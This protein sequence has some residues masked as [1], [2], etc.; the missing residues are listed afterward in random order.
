M[1]YLGAASDFDEGLAKKLKLSRTDMRCLELIG[2]LGP[3]TAGR[4]AEESGLT[5][6]AVTFI[7]DRLEE[8]GMVTRRRDTEDRR[9]VWV[10]IVPEAQERLQGL[11]QPVAE[12]MRQ[13]AQRFKADELAVVRDFMREAKEVFQR[14][15]AG[16][17]NGDAGSPHGDPGANGR[18]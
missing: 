16:A 17:V 14:Q 11:H 8:A 3:L 13:V 2:R 6:G 7:L 15:V 10:E 1:G 18:R 5:T 12:E 4:L 9:R